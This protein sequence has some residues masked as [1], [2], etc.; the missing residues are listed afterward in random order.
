VYIAMNRYDEAVA[1]LR[2]SIELRP[3][4]TGAYYQLARIY[5]KLGNNS[6]AA[7]QFQRVKYLESASTK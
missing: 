4:E 5:Q 2:R 1:A 3:M 7:E 6:L